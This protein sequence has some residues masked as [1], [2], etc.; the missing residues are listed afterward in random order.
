[1]I[2][3]ELQKLAALSYIDAELEE[4]QDEFGDLPERVAEKEKRVVRAKEVVDE[5]NEILDR[6]REFLVEAKA[7]LAEMKEREDVLTKQQFLVRNNK[8]FDAI[9]NELNTIKYQTSELSTQLSKE[10]VKESSL[11]R[12]LEEQENA[13]ANEKAELDELEKEIRELSSVQDEEVDVFYKKRDKLTP[14]INE[15]AMLEYN[16]VRVFH[17]DA[18]VQIR[19]NS[20]S[21]CYSSIP[22]QLIVEIRNNLDTVRHCENCGRI[23]L[24]EE[25][26]IDKDLLK[27]IK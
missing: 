19:K 7:T 10:I 8:E 25:F 14:K 5:T 22:S 17:K 16:R 21:G 15:K 1:M 4:L 6:L 24:P 12:L 26:V 2:D 18:A 23:L 27:E 20:C 13:F 11:M 3:Y 9:T